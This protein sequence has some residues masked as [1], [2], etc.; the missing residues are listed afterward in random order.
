MNSLLGQDVSYLTTEYARNKMVEEYR[1]EE[2][3]MDR[4]PG[5]WRVHKDEHGRGYEIYGNAPAPGWGQ[6][7]HKEVC[8]INAKKHGAKR[9]MSASYAEHPDDGA[10][11]AFIVRACNCHDELVEAVNRLL[12]PCNNRHEEHVAMQFAFD[13]LNKVSNAERPSPAGGKDN[14]QTE[15]PNK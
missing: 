7:G 11:A 3:K 8:R 2:K 6:L 1:R 15:E 9:G 4:T 5:P 14:N 10:N 12:A 13:V